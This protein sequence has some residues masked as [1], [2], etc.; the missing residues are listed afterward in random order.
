MAQER[1]PVI[2]AFKNIAFVLPREL[3]NAITLLNFNAQK[4]ASVYSAPDYPHGTSRF[5]DAARR[6]GIARWLSLSSGDGESG[7]VSSVFP[8]VIE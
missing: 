7:D 8:P 6:A 1:P 2:C 3:R 5:Q 4:N